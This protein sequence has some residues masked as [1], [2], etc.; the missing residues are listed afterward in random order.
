MAHWLMKTEPDECSID[1]F[2]QVPSKSI[3][4]DGVRNYQARNFMRKMQVGDEVLLYHSSCKLVGVAGIVVVTQTAFND[5][6]QFDPNSNY[7]DAK[8]DPNAV[9]KGAE[10]RWSAVKLKFKRKLSNVLSLQE[11]KQQNLLPENPLTRK[12]NRLSVIPISTD[13]FSTV[14]NYIR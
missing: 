6:T 5:P 4:W 12:G 8:S 11:I 10:A 7:F 1:D 13:E 14:L 9:I 2:A 3:T